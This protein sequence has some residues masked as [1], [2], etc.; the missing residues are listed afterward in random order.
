MI[1][2][3]EYLYK[4]YDESIDLGC[5][6]KIIVEN[7]KYFFN[8]NI[9]EQYVNQLMKEGYIDYIFENLKSHD[10]EKLK[11][12]LKEVF[13]EKIEDFKDYNGKENKSFYLILSDKANIQD[14]YNISK[15]LDADYDNIEK[16][17]NILEF[18]NYYISYSEKKEDKWTLFIEP[19]YSD[20][21]TKELENNHVRLYH[22]TDSKSA[23]SILKN[24]LRIKQSKYREFPERI[25]LYASNKKLDDNI[26]D[27]CKFISKICN[28]SKL[29]QYGLSILKLNIYHKGINIYND[30]AMKEK[31][32]VFVYNNIPKEYIKEI[33]NKNINYQEVCKYFK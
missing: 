17:N 2:L 25:F 30:T 27:I 16:F 22:F 1:S 3:E 28:R 26:E 7:M 21:I 13:G 24:G 31:E 18:F 33:K 29:Y 15:R 4:C 9:P 20:D 6:Q 12:K 19:R 10:T 32:A 11:K 14:F 23:E 8:D 5:Q